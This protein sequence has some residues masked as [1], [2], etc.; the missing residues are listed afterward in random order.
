M[1]DKVGNAI[2][3]LTGGLA[4]VKNEI[5]NLFQTPKGTPAPFGE[6]FHG[7]R[8]IIKLNGNDKPFGFAFG[9]TINIQT[10]HEEIW[11][12]D[13]YTPYELAPTRIQVS[14]TLSMFHVPGRGPS[15][16]LVQANVLS[17][18][19]HRY[20]TLEVRDAGTDLTLFKSNRVMITSRSQSIAAGELSTIQL[21]WKAVGWLDELLPNY[22]KSYKEPFA[23]P[24]SAAIGA[25]A[26][27][28]K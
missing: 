26:E 20:I 25:A 27:I 18:L 19:F 15:A 22:P 3:K 13:D 24:A 1:A 4:S 5:R 12:I 9:V 7:S 28:L 17:F 16:E 14:G 21:Q 8:A 2:D 23:D 6:F 11:T 10:H